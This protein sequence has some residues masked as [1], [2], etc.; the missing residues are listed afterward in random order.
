MAQQ[1]ARYTAHGQQSE[2]YASPLS[3]VGGHWTRRSISSVRHLTILNRIC[4]IAL[5]RIRN[6]FILTS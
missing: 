5:P 4:K 6:K 2:E 3:G 1:G